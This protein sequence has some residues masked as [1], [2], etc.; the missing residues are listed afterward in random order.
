[1]VAEASGRTTGSVHDITTV[2]KISDVSLLRLLRY[3]NSYKVKWFK[4]RAPA[5]LV[6]RAI[7][8]DTTEPVGLYEE[9]PASVPSFL[10]PFPPLQHYMLSST[11]TRLFSQSR[12][13]KRPTDVPAVPGQPVNTLLLP[14]SSGL[15]AT[16]K[17][18]DSRASARS[19]YTEPPRPTPTPGLTHP[20]GTMPPVPVRHRDVNSGWVDMLGDAEAKPPHTGPVRKDGPALDVPRLIMTG[21]ALGT[22]GVPHAVRRDVDLKAQLAKDA[23]VTKDKKDVEAR[24][25]LVIGKYTSLVGGPR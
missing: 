20:R 2:M 8:R 5:I 21:A 4:E 14:A 25:A 22:I 15:S 12:M 24:I 1:M 6:E 10:P 16:I 18:H 17:S 19:L 23:P 3:F 9:H 13:F 7:H 11:H